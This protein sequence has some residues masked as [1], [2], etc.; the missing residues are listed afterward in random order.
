MHINKLLFTMICF[1]GS[2]LLGQSKLVIY[3]NGDALIQETFSAQVNVGI[4]EIERSNVTELINPSSVKLSTPGDVTIFEQNYRFDLVNDD[5]LMKRYL[6]SEVTVQ[7]SNDEKLSGMLLSYDNRNIVIQGRTGLD[8]IERGR[9][10]SI[11]CPNPK[12]RLFVR[13]T[14]AWRIE[15]A[16]SAKLDFEL[17]YLSGGMNWSAEYVAVLS[18]D[19]TTMDLSSWINLSNTSGKRFQQ[20]SVKLIAGDVRRAR[21]EFTLMQEMALTAKRSANDVVER[22]FFEYHLYEIGFPVN[23]ANKES[24]QVQFLSPHQVQVQKRF[25]Y[26]SYSSSFSNIPIK[27]IFKNSQASGLGKPLPMGTV[28]LFQADTDGGLALIGEDH[29][30]HSSVDDL[31]TLEVGSAFDV[32]A[33]REVV[34]RRSRR[35]KESEEDVR[36]TLANR[37]GEAVEI[38]VIQRVAYE[39]WK[40][41]DNSHHFEK[42]D[43]QRIRFTVTVPARS[44]KEISYTSVV[45]LR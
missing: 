35:D 26:E 16:K 8:I 30:K 10:A 25:V 13:P 37:K 19:E 40:I 1:T 2:L 34:D 42:L 23:V 44:E 32:K 36:I 7:L 17:S 22:E 39:N 3:N 6:E 33:K 12:D 31:V 20:A 11:R 28:R 29:L 43:S 27:L 15:A 5:A 9:V 24:K 4:S 41:L 45:D 38:D 14:L 18:N 21:P